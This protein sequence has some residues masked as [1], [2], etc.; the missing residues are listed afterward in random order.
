MKQLANAV[1]EGQ[2]VAG[3]TNMLGDAWGDA[4][5]Q[6]PEEADLITFNINSARSYKQ[7]MQDLANGRRP[8]G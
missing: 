6:F 7:A 8:G 4:I 2:E 3:G 5:A 1:R